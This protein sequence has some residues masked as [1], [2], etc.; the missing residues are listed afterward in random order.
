MNKNNFLIVTDIDTD[1]RVAIPIK[2]II[3]LW[4]SKKTSTT[5]VDY[6]HDQTA[7]RLQTKESFDNIVE[8]IVNEN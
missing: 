1:C 4:E 5:F 6:Y 8:R 3:R 2:Y 7:V